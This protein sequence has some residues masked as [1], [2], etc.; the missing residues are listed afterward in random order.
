MK[1]FSS[2]PGRLYLLVVGAWL[3]VLAGILYLTVQQVRDASM[4]FLSY[5]V[6]A[7][8]IQQGK[9]LYTLE[10]HD[11]VSASIGIR[12][13]GRYLYPPT[14][15]I[16]I[17]P[18]LVL[19]P[20]AASLLWFFVNVSLLL[21]GVGILLSQS[22]LR[23]YRIRIA[24]LLLPVLFTPVLM[25][26]YLGQVNILIFTLIVLVWLSFV[27]GRRYTS[28]VMLALA[29][30]IKIWPIILIAYF[31]W[32]REWKVVSGAL[33]GLLLIGV[34]TFAL[35]GD[36]QTISFF[37]D[38]LPEISRGTEPGM[39]HLNQ[40]IPGVFA[41]LF[42]P[43][44]NYVHPLIQ[45]PM[46]AQQGS[47]VATLL[48]IGATVL[49]SSRPIVL[50]YR[51][52]FSIEFM[53][54]VIAAMLITGRLFESNLTL[55]LPAYFFI[56]EKLH[57]ERTATW[58]QIAL[59]VVSIMLIDLHRVIWTLANPDK[60]ALSWFLLIFPFLGVILIWFILAEMLLRESK[61]LEVSL[62]SE[63]N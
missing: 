58:G 35:A 12:M 1:N 37:T 8:A 62:L 61:T 45:S 55:L 15:A 42:A 39:D 25:T 56:A 13:V 48:L 6:G 16:L 52:Q 3:I 4:D 18:F 10:T 63:P 11:V 23:D 30:W 27:H 36:G 22:N 24:L 43:R 29:A 47:R 2:Y 20:Y 21:A 46:L 7:S 41:K 19:S 49:L 38:K 32:K 31:V 44:S 53:L 26:L 28:G 34:L 17:Q 40:S 33:I 60:Q 59:L 57:R 14:F 5:Y 9:P 50:K 51:E 54:V